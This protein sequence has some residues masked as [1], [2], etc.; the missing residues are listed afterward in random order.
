MTFWLC[1][2]FQTHPWS[3]AYLFFAAGGITVTA[4]LDWLGLY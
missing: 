1:N 3:T 2:H 4:C